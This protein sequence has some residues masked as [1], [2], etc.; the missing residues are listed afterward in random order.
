VAFFDYVL[1][2]LGIVTSVSEVSVVFFVSESKGITRLTYVS[3]IARGTFQLVNTTFTE[4][5]HLCLG[6]PIV[7]ERTQ[8][9]ISG[10]GDSDS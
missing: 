1:C 7:Q 2:K 6:V 3:L 5:A 10:E 9:V 8:F 4:L